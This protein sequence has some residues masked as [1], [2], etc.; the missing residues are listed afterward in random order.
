MSWFQANYE[1]AEQSQKKREK[2]MSEKKKEHKEKEKKEAKKE[3]KLDVPNGYYMGKGDERR[4]VLALQD[5]F[6]KF[7]LSD[8]YIN[9]TKAEKRKMT[10]VKFY[11]DLRKHNKINVDFKEKQKVYTVSNGEIETVKSRTTKKELP[12]FK[13]ISNVLV[14][15]VEQRSDVETD[16]VAEHHE[17]SDGGEES[18]DDYY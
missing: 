4:P 5:V 1:T 9:A 14:G 6:R 2:L 3:R 15:W 8:S 16:D 17:T 10:K 12:A 11:D 13:V 7:K 18:L